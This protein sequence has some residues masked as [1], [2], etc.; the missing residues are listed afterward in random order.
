MKRRE[1]LAVVLP[2]NILLMIFLSNISY[3]RTLCDIA[4]TDYRVGK[5]TASSPCLEIGVH[6]IGKLGLTITNRGTFGTGFVAVP[7]QT[8]IDPFTGLEA[9]S[10]TY[11]NPGKGSYLF[12]GAFW[13]GAV[14]G[15]DTLVSVGADGWENPTIEEMFSEICPYGAIQRRSIIKG[16]ID[17]ISE[18]DLIAVYTDTLTN[19]SFLRIDPTDNRPHKP[20]NIEVTQRSF[21]WSYAYAEDF[22]LFDYSIKNI[23]EKKLNI[24]YMGLYVD[25]DVG[26][27]EYITDDAT[28]DICGF[29][30]AISSPQDPTGRC[31]FIDTVNL[32]WIADN[33]GKTDADKDKPCSKETFKLPA[34]TAT[35]VVRTPNADTLKYS[36]NWWVSNGTNV[37]LDFGPRMQNSVEDPFRDF[38]GFLGTPSGDKNKYYIMRHE[39]FD[40]DQIYSA[41]DYSNNGWFSPNPML[42]GNIAD[43]FDTRYLLSFG[44]FNM[45]S[46]EVLPISFA[47]VAGDSFHRNCTD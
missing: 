44:P 47:Y 5:I 39:E 46:G 38:G 32:A 33:D 40:Y 12:G 16:D 28:D 13:I 43:G 18:Q 31:G 29:R 1:L 42:A 9:P 22:I 35:R 2:V 15:R 3:G 19:P 36:F 30:R 17:A 41:K 20:L 25:G 14:V 10:A 26:T 45:K 4:K 27:T 37:N 23:G 24:V 7:G 8:V 34:V 11:P 21:A 6:D